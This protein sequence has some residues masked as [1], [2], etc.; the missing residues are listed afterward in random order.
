MSKLLGTIILVA[1]LACESHANRKI[2]RGLNIDITQAPYHVSLQK[3]DPFTHTFYHNCGGSIIAPT[4]ILTAGHCVDRGF[5]NHTRKENS[6]VLVGTTKLS[7]PGIPHQIK[8]ITIH[9]NYRI[10]NIP[11]SEEGQYALNDIAII[12]LTSPIEYTDRAKP[13]RLP[14]NNI[15]AR[16]GT[17]CQVQGWGLINNTTLPDHLQSTGVKI[18][19]PNTCSYLWKEVIESQLSE[20]PYICAMGDNDN[21]PC[22]GDSGS[23]LLCNGVQT[24]IVSQAS[25]CGEYAEPWSAYTDVYQMRNFISAATKYEVRSKS[26]RRKY[27]V[28]DIALI[29]LTSPIEYTDRAK[30]IP[31]PSDNNSSILGTKCQV[32]GWGRTNNNTKPD[33]LK[34]ATVEI[35]DSNECT[36]EWKQMTDLQHSGVPYICAMGDNEN[37][38]CSGD[39]GSALICNGVQSG[40]VSQGPGDCADEPEPWS[41]FTDVFQMRDFIATATNYEIIHYVIM[42]NINYNS[43]MNYSNTEHCLKSYCVIP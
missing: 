19:Q 30:P 24:G 36:N 20:I 14:S 25:N 21:R 2:F 5:F 3:Y 26:G 29:E 17:L 34:S 11:L 39:S 28:D 12:E 40:V 10:I 43:I 16:L 6:H 7:E 32:Q 41:A 42:L 18:L 33:H 22:S 1:V 37:R 31:L 4:W 15:S 23:A 35:I 9:D 8:N 38:P 27:S 13:I